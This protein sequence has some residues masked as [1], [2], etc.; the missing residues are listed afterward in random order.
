MVSRVNI[1][2]SGTK[3]LAQ[4]LKRAKESLQVGW[5]SDVSYQDGTPVA[6]IAALNEYGT[7]TSPARPFFRPAIESNN[8]TWADT[9]AAG[10]KSWLN[11]STEY[12]VVLNG[13]GLQAQADVKTAIVSGNHAPLS[14]VT[15]ALRR[16]KNQGV[17]IGRGVVGA[18]ASAVAQGKT[19]AGELGAPFANQDPL[20]DTGYMISTLT[21]EVS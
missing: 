18:V 11:G 5:F 3:A 12:S 2:A 1:S 15:L 4:K 10:A 16:L 7:S 21:Y 17:P 8:S 19:G 20:R 13:V 6:G 9:F 14:P